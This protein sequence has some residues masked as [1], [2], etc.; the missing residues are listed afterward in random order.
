M[1]LYRLPYLI[2]STSIQGR[3]SYYPYFIDEETEAEKENF[4]RL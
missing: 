1:C 4:E 3:Y 2:V